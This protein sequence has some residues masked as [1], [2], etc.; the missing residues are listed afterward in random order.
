MNQPAITHTDVFM[1]GE[2]ASALAERAA[3]RAAVRVT[4]LAEGIKTVAGDDI[5]G[6][7]HIGHGGAEIIFQLE[8]NGLG[9]VVALAAEE[10]GRAAGGV[11]KEAV[12]FIAGLVEVL[13][14]LEERDVAGIDINNRAVDV[15]LA[16]AVVVGV[17]DE[18]RCG[19]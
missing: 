18:V 7:I 15:A 1:A 16:D 8:S 6:R 12:D 13:V 11:N 9:A 3:G 5:A 17:V 4:Y 10:D 14:S 19:V 2:A